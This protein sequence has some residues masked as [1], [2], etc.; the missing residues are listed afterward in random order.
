[1]KITKLV[2]GYLFAVIS[3]FLINSLKYEVIVFLHSTSHHTI[4]LCI[5]IYSSFC[6]SVALAAVEWKLEV[7]FVMGVI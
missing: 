2:C 7:T 5:F 6:C 3:Y 1:M 4:T